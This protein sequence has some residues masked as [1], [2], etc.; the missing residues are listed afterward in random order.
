MEEKSLKDD[1]YLESVEP[2]MMTFELNR[3]TGPK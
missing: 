1:G 3:K 2:L